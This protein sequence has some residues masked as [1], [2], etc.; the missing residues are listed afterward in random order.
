[1]GLEAVDAFPLLLAEL[2]RRGWSEQ[3]VVNAA[4][5]NFL[6]V[7]TEAE[8]VAARLRRKRPASDA[9]LPPP[10]AN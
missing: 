10:V 3:E 7:L 8:R 1:V 2:L 6:R 9:R 5:G 4:G